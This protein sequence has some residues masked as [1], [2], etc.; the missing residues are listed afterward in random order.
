M[1][2]GNWKW[3]PSDFD[4]LEDYERAKSIN[5]SPSEYR[6]LMRLKTLQDLKNRKEVQLERLRRLRKARERAG[7][8]EDQV[9]MNDDTACAS[10]IPPKKRANTLTLLERAMA[11]GNE[12]I[13]VLSSDDESSPDNN[14]PVIV[15]NS[16]K[17]R[18]AMRSEYI[19]LDSDD[20]EIVIVEPV[21]DKQ[22]RPAVSSE[23]I[24]LDSDN[25][26]DDDMRR[27]LKLSMIQFKAD[28]ERKRTKNPN[29][30]NEP[31]AGCSTWTPSDAKKKKMACSPQFTATKL[32]P[33]SCK[34]PAPEESP[35]SP[36]SPKKPNPG[37]RKS[38]APEESPRS[39]A[40]P[41]K[42]NPEE[43]PRSPASPKKPNPVRRI[44]PT[45]IGDAS[46]TKSDFGTD[47]EAELAA[48]VRHEID[49]LTEKDRDDADTSTD[50]QVRK[51][52]RTLDS[53]KNI[54]EVM[55]SSLE[56]ERRE[57]KELVKAVF[58]RI[59]ENSKKP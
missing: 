26:E 48:R 27:A 37:S 44:V 13:Q 2:D 51:I 20:D 6:V 42:P 1:S 18:P 54:Q 46:G 39:P 34:S 15:P 41:K 40:S 17:Q 49:R 52:I 29:Y 59:L 38:P 25:E 55:G 43:S 3:K 56:R 8:L 35:R 21:R 19:N 31:G 28:A 7:N 53:A 11:S 57:K 4:C 50:D 36:A 24:N 16:D 10:Y 45:R 9:R 5:V 47:K 12:E 30:E 58:G 33:G 22:K 32:N 23:C 14:E